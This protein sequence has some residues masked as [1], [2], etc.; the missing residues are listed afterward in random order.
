MMMIIIIVVVIFSFSSYII[1]DVVM[2]IFI[3]SHLFNSFQLLISK[4]TVSLSPVFETV[5]FWIL[6]TVLNNL[7]KI[8]SMLAMV[9]YVANG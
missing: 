7:L 4:Y 5:P 2:Y 9:K 8:K 3:N 1:V 6:S